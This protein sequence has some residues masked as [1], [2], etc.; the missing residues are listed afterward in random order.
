MKSKKKKDWKKKNQ[1]PKRK[2]KRG[3]KLRLPKKNTTSLCF[4]FLWKHLSATHNRRQLGKFR[5]KKWTVQQFG[6]TFFFC[7]FC[8]LIAS[9]REGFPWWK[10]VR[11]NFFLRLSSHRNDKLFFFFGIFYCENN[12]ICF[13][14]SSPLSSLSLHNTNKKKNKPQ[15]RHIENARIELV[16]WRIFFF[17]IIYKKS[18][19]WKKWKKM[20]KTTNRDSHTTRKKKFSPSQVSNT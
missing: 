7:R 12:N 20:K 10:R 9:F 3:E 15:C 17:F 14:F 16:C 6:K 11:K 2:K 5:I 4:L 1:N 8:L 18:T 13:L 19:L